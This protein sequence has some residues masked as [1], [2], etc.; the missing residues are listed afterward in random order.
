MFPVQRQRA[1][2]HRGQ[3]G[4]GEAAQTAGERTAAEES[5]HKGEL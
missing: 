2:D 4:E 5:S 1:G 3:T